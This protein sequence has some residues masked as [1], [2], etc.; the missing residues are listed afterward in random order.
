M[1]MRLSDLALR[2][3]LPED[4]AKA[5]FAGVEAS[6]SGRRFPSNTEAPKSSAWRLT[7]AQVY[8]LRTQF[9]PIIID[10]FFA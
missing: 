3:A 1:V 6:Y 4:Q 10:T 8:T 7:R 5:G 9:A 2:A